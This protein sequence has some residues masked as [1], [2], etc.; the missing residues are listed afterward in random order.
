MLGSTFEGCR[1]LRLE[2]IEVYWTLLTPVTLIALILEFYKRT[3]DFGE[4]VKRIFLSLF[5]LWSFEYAIGIVAFLSDGIVER[6]GGLKR[7]P[8]V[9]EQLHKNFKG[10]MPG[11]M[12]FRQ[13][14]IFLI[15]FAC[16]L[17][18]LLSFYLTEI[19]SHFL[20]A[21]LYVVSP[22][23]FLCMIPSQ[24]QHIAK[25]IYKG[26]INIAVWRVLWSILGA[27]L[28]EFIR[29]PVANWGNFFMGALTNLCI[30]ASMLLI[31]FFTRSLI[32]DGGTGV[33]SGAMALASLPVAR[34][35][36]GIPLRALRSTARLGKRLITGKRKKGGSNEQKK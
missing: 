33:A 25:N 24:T 17:I 19:I 8:L 2:M 14:L 27:M 20:Y 15:N 36:Q 21:I 23:A 9:L 31:P 4:I 34:G 26:I 30:G 3:L 35:I 16:Y 1:E 5:L 29:S 18:A 10:D 22:L 13:M 32:N 28:F 6:M 7:L 11:M 12:Q